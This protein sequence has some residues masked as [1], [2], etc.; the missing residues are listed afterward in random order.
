MMWFWQMWHP[1]KNA[2]SKRWPTEGC[3]REAVENLPR[4]PPYQLSQEIVNFQKFMNEPDV[5]LSQKGENKETF[6][7]LRML[8]TIGQ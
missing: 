8:Q 6:I 5:W 4:R 7:A 2:H 3:G 1:F